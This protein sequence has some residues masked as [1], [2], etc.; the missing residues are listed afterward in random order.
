[1]SAWIVARAHI[2]VLVQGLYEGE[3]VTHLDPDEVGRVLW[4]ECLA[5]VAY[6]YPRDQDGERSAPLDFRDRNV[7]TYTY[8]RPSLRIPL[9]GLHHAIRCYRYQSCEHPDWE[10]SDAEAWTL[11][12]REA[13]ARHPQVDTDPPFGDHP[14][15]YEETDVHTPATPKPRELAGR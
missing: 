15:G 9:T 3:H 14:W 11:R 5:S 8:R 12:L 6:L 7:E 13:V 4:R 2:D 10:G 1:V